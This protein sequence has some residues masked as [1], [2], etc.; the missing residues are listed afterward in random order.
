M[1]W[2][3]LS[4]A[5]LMEAARV[6]RE[7]R[8]E[9]TRIRQ[10]MLLALVTASEAVPD[11]DLRRPQQALRAI[12][13]TLRCRNPFSGESLAVCKRHSVTGGLTDRNFKNGADR[14][15][16]EHHA[17]P[18]GSTFKAVYGF[19][20]EV[21]VDPLLWGHGF[22]RTRVGAAKVRFEVDWDS[23]SN[24]PHSAN[25]SFCPETPEE[26]FWMQGLL[27]A[28]TG[29]IQVRPGRRALSDE[30]WIEWKCHSTGSKRLWHLC[31]TRG[32]SHFNAIRSYVTGPNGWTEHV[33]V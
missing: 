16:F 1:V 21:Q 25:L 33:H 28:L 17:Y 14:F 22:E 9:C 20:A 29:G 19:D 8:R 32:A 18:C 6:N 24:V 4:P 27:Q 23:C 11:A 26:S 2:S 15:R 10:D 5:Q 7:W 30:L 13:R 12:Q 3:K 31:R